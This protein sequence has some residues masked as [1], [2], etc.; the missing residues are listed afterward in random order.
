MIG[1]MTRQDEPPFPR[2]RSRSW[3]G[4]H[5]FTVPGVVALV[6]LTGCY[7]G[8]DP[9][10]KLTGE[11]SSLTSSQI[12]IGPA[13]GNCMLTGE[14]GTGVTVSDQIRVG[15]CVVVTFRGGSHMPAGLL[16]ARP[17]T[18]SATKKAIKKGR[19]V[20]TS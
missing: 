16:S 3:L 14:A 11:V 1:C 5:L 12:C 13:P 4:R 2:E 15:E 17:A 20:T 10:R 6:M 8:D 7:T 19:C 18:A 9:P